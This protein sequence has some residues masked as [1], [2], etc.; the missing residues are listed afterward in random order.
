MFRAPPADWWG[1]Y[2]ASQRL[3]EKASG[4][5]LKPSEVSRFYFRQGLRY[6]AEQPGGA[7]G[8][9][10]H[11]LVLF[12]TPRELGNNKD[13]HFFTDRFTPI[14]R[15]LP[16]SFIVIAPLA[17]AGVVLRWRDWRAL[18][19]LWGFVV[20][21]TAGVVAFFVNSRFRAPIVPVLLLFAAEAVAWGVSRVRQRAWSQVGGIALLTVCAGVLLRIITTPQ[22]PQYGRA[23]VPDPRRGLL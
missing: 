1:G 18:M 15:L 3:A 13:P 14:V 21:Y 5:P 9:L 17:L 4:R 11:K 16:L 7:L 23:L 20:V 22:V 10:L 2:F 6:W 19:P 12:W 8:L